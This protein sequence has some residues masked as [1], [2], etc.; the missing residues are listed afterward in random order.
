MLLFILNTFSFISVAIVIN[1][2]QN[3][4]ITLEDAYQMQYKSL[5]LADELRQSSDDL[6][7]MARTYVITGNSMFEEQYKTVLDIR[8]GAKP[9]P[10]KY[11]GIYW[12]FYAIDENSPKL[13]GEIVA[14]RE[15]MKKANFPDT[16]LNLL[17]TSQNESDDLTKL[18]HKAMNAVKGIFQDEK[19]EYTIKEKPDF[20]LARELM[21]SDR[22]HEAKIRIMQPLD[23]FYKA[24]ESRTKAEVDK[25]RLE[26]KELEFSVNV[27]VLLASFSME[28]DCLL[29]NVS[30]LKIAIG[31]LSIL[32]PWFLTITFTKKFE[33]LELE[34]K[35]L[36]IEMLF[37]TVGTS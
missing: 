8:N 9:R 4:T 20:K 36:S 18:E 19:G 7:R 14:L 26:V 21:H 35:T 10:K 29:T 37:K 2:Y 28:K 6:T 17:F 30:L 1:K 13:T 33:V 15:L 16:E 31:T 27:I 24:F 23:K 5:I 22:Y 12:D 11:N 3:S 25:S 34:I 32:L